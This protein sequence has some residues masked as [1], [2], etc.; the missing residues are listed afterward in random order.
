MRL[1]DADALFNYG[2]YK[3]SDAVKYGNKSEEQQ[4]FSYSTMM[5][6]E[7]ADEILDAPTVDPVKRG[8]WIKN[9]VESEK[10]VE[11]IYYCSVCENFD[12]WG[13]TE[14]YFYCPNCGAK[15]T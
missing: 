4:H 2:K 14:K 1:I 5:M 3:L 11:A 10:H 12:A 9:E 13:E 6:Y 8:E 15:M 7:I